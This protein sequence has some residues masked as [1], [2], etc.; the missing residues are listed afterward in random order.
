MRLLC[1][2]LTAFLLLAGVSLPALAVAQDVECGELN[3]LQCGLLTV[4]R[5]NWNERFGDSVRLAGWK[6]RGS[7][8]FDGDWQAVADLLD[9]DGKP[10]FPEYESGKLVGARVGDPGPR[11]PKENIRYRFIE[12]IARLVEHSVEME[13]Q[14]GDETFRTTALA[15]RAYPHLYGD[16]ISNVV[17]S[18]NSNSCFH[19]HFQWLWGAER[20]EVLVDLVKI[21]TDA[22]VCKR[23][24]LSWFS[25][26]TVEVQHSDIEYVRGLCRTKYAW[27][28]TTPLATLAFDDA[29]FKFEV[30]GLGSKAV[31]G[32]DCVVS[33]Q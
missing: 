26:G 17:L 22:S 13:W 12:R 4:A 1:R 21:K 8:N 10:W 23:V 11:D 16:M 28:V 9:R 3:E 19:K 20:G 18:R 32:G 5:D 14:R 25:F 7:H 27:G 2:S 29:G 30:S 24:L 6:Y 33:G 15:L 31:G